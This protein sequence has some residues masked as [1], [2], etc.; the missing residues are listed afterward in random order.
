MGAAVEV[1]RDTRRAA[2]LL[3][4]TR[5]RV[6]RELAQPDSASGLARRLGLP[7]Q[8]VNYHLRELE[9]EGLVEPVE[10]RRKGNCIER[11][12]RATARSYVISP[13]V[14]GKL[15]GEPQAAQ[16]RFSSAYLVAVAARAIRDVAELRARADRAGKRLATLTLETEVRFASADERKAFGEELATAIARLA[17]KYHDARAEGGRLYRFVVGGYPKI[18]T[19]EGEQGRDATASV[20]ME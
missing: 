6:I 14:L 17:A 7:R 3:N 19:G 13:D 8:H 2:A 12:V 4:A 10:E 18:T 20:R 15:G 16:D 1:I 11:V 9:K 5:L